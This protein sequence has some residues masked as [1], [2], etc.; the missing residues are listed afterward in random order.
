VYFDN[1]ESIDKKV[2]KTS[3]IDDPICF[4]IGW[5]SF[6]TDNIYDLDIRLDSSQTIPTHTDQVRNQLVKYNTGNLDVLEAT[7]FLQIMSV[8]TS[9]IID[10]DEH[11]VD[12]DSYRFA[13]MYTPMSTGEY[14][15]N[16]FE[17]M[18]VGIFFP[19]II[20]LFA[21]IGNNIVSLTKED[22][23]AK[24]M[25]ILKQIG[26]APSVHICQDAILF[27]ISV[28]IILSPIL[29]YFWMHIFYDTGLVL[30]FTFTWMVTAQLFMI[31]I[32]LQYL[33]KGRAR[34]LVMF[35]Y[36][37]AQ[38]ILGALSTV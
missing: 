33:L 12:P 7:G 31:E 26:I 32:I 2:R 5:N 18:I 4:A 17:S 37:L 19:L 27:L 21:N 9:V 29:V 22:H 38:F 3:Y 34:F 23:E 20:L 24:I 8:A 28:L 25:V 35:V 36:Y 11:D 6:L 10:S 16:T 13:M 30:I 14:T 1:N 15:D